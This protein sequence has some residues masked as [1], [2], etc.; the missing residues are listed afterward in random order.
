M[1]IK[2]SQ[3]SPCCLFESMHGQRDNG[4]ILFCLPVDLAG[5]LLILFICRFSV[6]F[7][8]MA[9]CLKSTMCLVMKQ[10]ERVKC[11]SQIGTILTDRFHAWLSGPFCLKKFNLWPGHQ[12]RMLLV[13]DEKLSKSV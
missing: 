3:L 8:A 11:F 2:T 5:S 4:E 6:V 1:F 7:C 10:G 12:P 9:A 13:E